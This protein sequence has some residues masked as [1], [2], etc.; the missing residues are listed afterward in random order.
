MRNKSYYKDGVI[1]VVIIVLAIA[2]IVNAVN[3]NNISQKY[4][5]LTRQ[6]EQSLETNNDLTE[7][8]EHVKSQNDLLKKENKELKKELSK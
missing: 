6:Y 4:R 8:L 5:E 2:N 7:S 1:L 3:N